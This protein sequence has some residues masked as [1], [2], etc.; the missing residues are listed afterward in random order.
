MFTVKTL[1]APPVFRTLF[2][3]NRNAHDYYTRQQEMSHVPK[4][5]RMEPWAIGELLYGII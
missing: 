1:P 2:T 4:S 5:K 3:K